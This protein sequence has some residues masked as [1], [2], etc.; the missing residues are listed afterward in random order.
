[1]AELNEGDFFLSE[2]G[3][4]DLDSP[5]ADVVAQSLDLVSVVVDA[6]L[7]IGIQPPAFTKIC[8]IFML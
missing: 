3:C 1:M 6:G 7:P 4:A 2:A 5:G 8:F